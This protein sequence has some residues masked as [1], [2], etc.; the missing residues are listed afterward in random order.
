[1]STIKYYFIVYNIFLHDLDKTVFKN[2]VTDRHP[3]EWLGMM[4]GQRVRN[5]VALIDY[6]PI[7]EKE[8]ELFKN[9]TP[10]HG[11]D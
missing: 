11:K 5:R 4:Q 7:N 3:F 10:A 6:K 8:Y 2:T 1:M 9:N